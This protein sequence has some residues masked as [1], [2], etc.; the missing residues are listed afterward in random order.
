M[1]IILYVTGGLALLALAWLFISLANT[2]AADPF[3]RQS[4]HDQRHSHDGER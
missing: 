3:E 1:E 2:A 4:D